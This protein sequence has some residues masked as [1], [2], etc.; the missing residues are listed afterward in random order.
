MWLQGVYQQTLLS[1]CV[2][3]EESHGAVHL[4]EPHPCPISSPGWGGGEFCIS[5]PSRAGPAKEDVVLLRDPLVQCNH[6]FPLSLQRRRDLLVL[7]THPSAATNTSAQILSF[8]LHSQPKGQLSTALALVPENSV[9]VQ[10]LCPQAGGWTLGS[11]ANPLP[12]QFA[13][14]RAE[15]MESGPAGQ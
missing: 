15:A 6:L 5:P 13:L 3:K 9:P 1:P 4:Q 2:I 7:N 14:Q 12:W 10:C 11:P 8:L